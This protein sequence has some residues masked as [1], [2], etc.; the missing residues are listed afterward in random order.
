MGLMV[1]VTA[2]WAVVLLQ[3]TPSWEPWLTALVIVAA[4]VALAGLAAPADMRRRLA[5]ATAVA[6]VVACLAAPLAYTAQTI[7]SAHSG[8][9]AVGRTDGERR[10]G[11]VRWR[12]WRWRL[13][14]RSFPGGP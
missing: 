8:S 4:L 13:G 9:A 3:R 7:A 6:A 5:A 12:A 10:G 2:A 11:R 1:A 14:A